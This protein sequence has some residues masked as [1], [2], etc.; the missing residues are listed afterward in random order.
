MGTISRMLA[1]VNERGAAKAIFCAL[2]GVALALFAL[3]NISSLVL[4][5][6]LS[7]SIANAQ[8]FAEPADESSPDADVAIQPDAVNNIAGT[9]SG[10]I[11]DSLLGG[12]TLMLTISQKNNAAALKGTWT[13]M[14]SSGNSVGKLKGSEHNGTGTINLSHKQHHHGV[15]IIKA[16]VTVPDATHMNGTYMT[17]GGCNHPSNGNFMLTMP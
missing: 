13:A 16:M 4:R 1:R 9:W 12:G 3:D 14:F 7:G 5:G 15:C 2:L 8:S 6:D 17:T 11:T 10:P